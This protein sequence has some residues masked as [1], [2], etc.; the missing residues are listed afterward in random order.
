[1]EVVEQNVPQST[2]DHHAED[3]KEQQIV[4]VVSG[5]R[6][7]LFLRI[8]FEEKV[9]DDEREHVHQPV[10]AKLNRAKLKEDRVNVWELELKH[11]LY[12]CALP[13]LHSQPAIFYWLRP[14]GLAFAS[15]H[16]SPKTWA[17]N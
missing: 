6:K 17:V 16:V 4:D 3:E 1:M 9:S 10:P 7:L 14:I 11:H 8:P 13:G 5:V 12:G 15:A 2:S